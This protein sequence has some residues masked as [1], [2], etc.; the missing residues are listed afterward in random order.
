MTVNKIGITASFG[1]LSA[2][3]PL[4]SI[5]LYFTLQKVESYAKCIIILKMCS[6]LFFKKKTKD[7][8]LITLRN[9]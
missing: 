1:I 4:T 8:N 7:K 2:M 6:Y 3:F 9:K 5:L